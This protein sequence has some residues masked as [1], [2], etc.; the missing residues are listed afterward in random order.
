[1][2]LEDV[3]GDLNLKRRQEIYFKHDKTPPHNFR[4]EFC[5]G[6]FEIDV[7]DPAWDAQQLE[8]F[9]VVEEVKENFYNFLSVPKDADTQ[10]IKSAFRKLSLLLH[11][12]KNSAENAEQQFR[13]LVAIYDVLKDTTKRKYYDEV[14]VNGLPN[15]RSAIYY[16]RHVRRIG[17]LELCLFLFVLISIGQYLVG[18][19]S[20]FERRYSLEQVRGKKQKKLASMIEVPKPSLLDTLPVQ[21]PKLIWKFVISLPW[22]FSTLKSKALEKFENEPPETSEDESVPQVKTLR[23]RKPAFVIPDGPTFEVQPKENVHSEVASHNVVSPVSGGLWTDDDLNE[24]VQLINRYPGGTPKRWEVI[25]EAIGRSVTEVTFMANKIKSNNFRLETEETKEEE[26]VR[27][28]KKTKGG[29][30]GNDTS[31]IDQSQT[32][33]SQEQQ[34]ALENALAKFPKGVLDRW[35]C[36]AEHVQG[37]TKEQC[38]LRYKYLVE[39]IKKQKET[40]IS[41]NN[42]D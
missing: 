34:K 39:V 5:D 3:S 7:L 30:L 22:M 10:T 42:N 38:I 35:D 32:V 12:D 33:W 18:W 4:D 16:Y 36:I 19:A 6:V 29:K 23:K 17:L 40:C 37:K 8:V 24:L 15:W 27:V 1:M 28:K 9:D 2:Y 14:L 26:E 13:N 20:Y 31:P 21:V 11:P 25:A 41:E